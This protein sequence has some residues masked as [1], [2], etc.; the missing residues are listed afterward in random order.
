MLGASP[1]PLQGVA[2]A[3]HA[4]ADVLVVGAGLSGARLC[5]R[6]RAEQFSGRIALLGAEPDLPYD[7]P[8]LTS[9]PDSDTDL[10]RTMGIDVRA[11]ADE[12]QLGRRAVR[13]EAPAAGTRVWRVTT[14]HDAGQGLIEARVVVVATGAEPVLPT[15]WEAA[16]LLHTRRQADWLW[17]RVGPGS[18]LVI[19]GGG[20]IG[21]EVA[22]TAAARGAEVVLLEAGEQ[23]LPGRM[24]SRAAARVAGLLESVGVDVRLGTPVVE[25]S[26]G[27]DRVRVGTAAGVVA[28]D[29]A[30]AA[31]GVRPETTWLPDEVA[32]SAGGAVLTDPW[33][34]TSLPGLLALG[35]AAAR[36]SPR[37]GRHLPG[38]HWTEAFSCA[39]SVAPAVL[40]WLAESSAAGWQQPVARAAE[41]PIAYTFS[42]LGTQRLLVLGDASA[43]TEVWREAGGGWADYVLDD[44]GKLTGVVAL[45]RPRDVVAAR[46]AMRTAAGGRPRVDR[47]ALAD[48]DA[49]PGRCFPTG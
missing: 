18:R 25:V 31:L 37:A 45:D 40:A 33:G 27:A 13:L 16:S 29:V 30:V 26:A 36:W 19:V 8:P 20:W 3:T 44:D 2:G 14:S 34:R 4:A 21:C 46:T 32:R 42:D 28:G 7:R 10:A 49:P 41:D 9:H 1:D 11:L 43:G 23:V 48:P 38:G 17:R 39:E 5:Q 24:P 6:L 12:V 35:D 47:S 22:R 15:G